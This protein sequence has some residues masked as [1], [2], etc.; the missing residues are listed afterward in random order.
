MSRPTPETDAVAEKNI[1]GVACKVDVD[2][3]RKLERERDEAREALKKCREDSI[4]YAEHMRNCGY[5]E[6]YKESKENADRAYRIL[7]GTK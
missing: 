3:A 1:Y 5:S 2:F 6:A 7:E 4:C